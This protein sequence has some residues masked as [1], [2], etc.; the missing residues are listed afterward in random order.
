MLDRVSK[1]DQL[2]TQPI[3]H[4]L[5]QRRVDEEGKTISLRFPFIQGS[6]VVRKEIISTQSQK[7][8]N[9]TAGSEDGSSSEGPPP[10]D[11]DP[12]VLKIPKDSSKNNSSL[13]PVLI[14]LGGSTALA[15]L[16]HF[17]EDL[18]GSLTKPIKYISIFAALFLAT[19]G[20]AIGLT[21]KNSET[22]IAETDY[23]HSIS[24]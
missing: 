24:L 10:T 7:A 1:L 4:R 16:T 12:R 18:L 15:A 13:L 2:T 3:Q 19:V 21:P 8:D 20:A 22:A 5:P 6:A 11:N 9:L 14:S 17:K 23:S